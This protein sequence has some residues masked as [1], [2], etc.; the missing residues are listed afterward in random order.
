MDKG[1]E[2]IASD[3]EL[4]EGGGR[5]ERLLQ[6]GGGLEHAAQQIAFSENRTLLTERLSICLGRS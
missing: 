5:V 4:F 6:F 2:L 1:A 3:A